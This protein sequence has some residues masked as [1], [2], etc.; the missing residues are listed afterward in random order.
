MNNNLYEKDKYGDLKLTKKGFKVCVIL[1][2]I[3]LFAIITLFSSFKTI[4][5]GEV[6]LKVRFGKITDTS[7]NEGLNLKIPY[8]EKIVKVNIKVQKTELKT[9]S[10]SKDLQVITTLL[11]VN[12]NVQKQSATTLYKNVGKDYEK[13]ILIPAIQES[14]K[15]VMSSFTAEEVITKRNQVSDLC[16]EE[17]Q[18]KVEKYGIN[19]D[20]FN[21]IDLDF[22]AE[23]SKAIEEKQVAEQKVLTAK[24]ELEREKIEAEKK[25]VKAKAE[26][27]ANELKQ[28]TLTDNIIK[29]KFI[30]KWN[31]ELP[32]ATNGN[33][34]FNLDSLLK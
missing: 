14:I 4:K 7:L 23:Y 5:S 22:S 28:K 10:S 30:E 32:K 6:G 17:I 9:E 3:L 13:T 18:S 19:I 26:K 12:Y 2:I 21:I 25:L 1:P 15:A 24:Q 34:I 11:A 27:E 8:I 29:E 31:G 33:A 16:L 20:D